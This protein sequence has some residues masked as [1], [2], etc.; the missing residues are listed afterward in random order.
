MKKIEGIG[1]VKGTFAQG[2]QFQ[3]IV[4]NEVSTF[5]NEFVKVSGVDGVSK[6]DA[7]KSARGNL[8]WLQ[9]MISH[10]AEIFTPLIPALVVG[11][12]ILGFRNV[13]GDIKMLEDGTKTLVEASQFWQVLTISYG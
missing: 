10:L 2:G 9:R 12:L 7:K 4:G 13:I 11:G 6:D 1:A 8:N 3:V 5:Y